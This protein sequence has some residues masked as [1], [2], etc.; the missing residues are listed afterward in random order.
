[1]KRLLKSFGYAFKGLFIA[2]RE[3]QNMRIH[4]LAVFVVVGFGIYIG[5]NAVEWSVITLTIG[6][7]LVSEML[8]SAIEDAVNFISPELNPKAARI[9]DI[10]AGAV[11]VTAVIGVCVAILIFGNKLFNELL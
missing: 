4:L 10:A 5:L 6:L 7:V 8:N 11:L 3:Q 1:M 2:I 9:K